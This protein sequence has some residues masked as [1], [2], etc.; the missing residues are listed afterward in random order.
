VG[1]EEMAPIRK[2]NSPE[3]GGLEKRNLIDSLKPV[4]KA[5]HKLP[6]I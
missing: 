4:G 1:E 5:K 3:F 6:E 2:W